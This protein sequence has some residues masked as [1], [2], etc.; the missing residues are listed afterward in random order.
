MKNKQQGNI[1]EENLVLETGLE[2]VPGSGCGLLFK[3]DLQNDYWLAEGKSSR[4]NHLVFNTAWW[5]KAEAQALLKRKV[6]SALLLVFTIRFD[7]Y[8]G[9]LGIAAVQN[10]LVPSLECTKKSFDI[11]G[12]THKIKQPQF[13]HIYEGQ[14]SL[15]RVEDKQKRTAQLAFITLPDFQKLVTKTS[16]DLR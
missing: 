3:G 2:L 14:K 13:E 1:T 7:E 5:F 10:H 16:N 9:P 12:T 15:V 4:N 8:T 6:Y 11:H